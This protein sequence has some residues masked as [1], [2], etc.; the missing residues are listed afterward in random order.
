MKCAVEASAE[1]C[2]ECSFSI[3]KT[4]PKFK[5]LLRTVSKEMGL[6]ERAIIRANENEGR[7]R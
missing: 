4:C 6:Y 5:E 3:K 2:R 1:V 7:G